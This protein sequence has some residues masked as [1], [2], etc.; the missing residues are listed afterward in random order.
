MA[1]TTN[2]DAE[3]MASPVTAAPSCITENDIRITKITS[4]YRFI[5]YGLNNM[6]DL[7]VNPSKNF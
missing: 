1:L 6:T 2:S 3:T 4:Q 7:V 5:S